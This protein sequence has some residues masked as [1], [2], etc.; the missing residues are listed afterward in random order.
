[1]RC[2]K[3]CKLRKICKRYDLVLIGTGV[4]SVGA[5]KAILDHEQQTTLNKKIL[6]IQDFRDKIQTYD[7]NQI[8]RKLGGLGN[9]P[10]WHG[11][12]PTDKVRN[13][14]ELVVGPKLG[15]EKYIFVPLRAPSPALLIEKLKRLKNVDYLTGVV[16]DLKE[17]NDFVNVRLSDQRIILAN[18]VFMCSGLIGTANILETSGLFGPNR[19]VGDHLCGFA[20]IYSKSFIENKFNIQLKS[21]IMQGGYLFPYIENVDQDLMIMFR[22]ARLEMKNPKEQIRTGPSYGK[23]KANL[24]FHILKNRKF[25]RLIE[26]LELKFGSRFSSKY[27]SLHFQ[28]ECKTAFRL[29]STSEHILKNY[30]NDEELKKITQILTNEFSLAPPP[31]QALY[32]GTHLFGANSHLQNKLNDKIKILDSLGMESIGG[33]HHSVRMMEKAYEI[34]SKA[35]K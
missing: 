5:L 19:V 31:N 26:A 18:N 20:G 10:Y 30:D 12:Y 1:M 35:L 7:N 4:V 33:T 21:K 29:D 13:V 9:A 34:V 2:E 17:E 25:G 11:V 3:G 14:N 24:L 27:Y 32:H 6:V 22:P 15:R 8:L 16:T 23:S 28:Y